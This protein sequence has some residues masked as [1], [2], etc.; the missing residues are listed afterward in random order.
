MWRDLRTNVCDVKINRAYVECVLEEMFERDF[1]VEEVEEL[2]SE[3]E[4]RISQKLNE[5][6]SFSLHE[7]ILEVV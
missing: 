3:I 5:G 7:I 1:S 4:Y 6:V 2:S